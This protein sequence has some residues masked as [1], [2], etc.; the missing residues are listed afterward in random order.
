[1]KSRCGLSDIC[2][3]VDVAVCRVE[4]ISA[5]L[6]WFRSCSDDEVQ[7]FIGASQNSIIALMASR[8]LITR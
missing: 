4:Q 2:R 6:A 5:R 7:I 3:L 1:V 8:S